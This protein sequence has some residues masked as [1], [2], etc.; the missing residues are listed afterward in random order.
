MEDNVPS[1]TGLEDDW[2]YRYI[3]GY[4][5]EKFDDIEEIPEEE[6]HEPEM[7][8]IVSL[9]EEDFEPEIPQEDEE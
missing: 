9:G 7:F 6:T 5:Y 3:E 1:K 2:F 8:D 4:P